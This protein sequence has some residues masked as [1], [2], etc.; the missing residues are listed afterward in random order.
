MSKTKKENQ[1]TPEDVLELEGYASKELYVPILVIN[2]NATILKQ[3]LD[4]IEKL[5]KELNN[6]NNGI[7]LLQK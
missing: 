6:D 5:E 4:R 1:Y 2:N 7:K 3:L